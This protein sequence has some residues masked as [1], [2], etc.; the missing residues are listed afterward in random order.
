MA[1]KKKGGKAV[2]GGRPAVLSLGKKVAKAPAR[3]KKTVGSAKG[4]RAN[5]R[6]KLSGKGRRTAFKSRSAKTGY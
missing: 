6:L 5:K 2:K 1:Q 3:G 4:G